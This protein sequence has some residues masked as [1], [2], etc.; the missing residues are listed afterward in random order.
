VIGSLFSTQRRRS[1]Q[2]L[3]LPPGERLLLVGAGTGLDFPYIPS[4][5]PFTAT[6]ITPAMVDRMVER[7]HRLGLSA[8]IRV[9]DGHHLAFDDGSFDAVGLHLILAVIPDPYQ[10]IREAVRVLRPGGRIAV[11]DKFLPDKAAPSLPRRMVNPVARFF[12]SDINRRAGEIVK[13]VP[14]STIHMEPVALGGLFKI[15]IL[16]KSLD[17]EKK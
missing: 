9:M 13:S 12:F 2:L 6:D 16:K 10:C 15:L 17:F 4:A 3:D 5:V 7:A 14:V 11:L 1:L 8:D